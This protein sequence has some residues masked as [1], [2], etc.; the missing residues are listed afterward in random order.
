MKKEWYNEKLKCPNC[1]LTFCTLPITEGNLMRFQEQYIKTRSSK[2]FKLLYDELLPYTESLLKQTKG[3][4][5]EDSEALKYFADKIIRFLAEEYLRDPDFKIRISFAGYIKNGHK[6]EQAL[7]DKEE[8]GIIAESLNRILPDGKEI[9]ISSK[10][11]VIEEIIENESI[12]KTIEYLTK[13]VVDKGEEFTKSPFSK[14][15]RLTSFDIDIKKNKEVVNNFFKIN[16]DYSR[17]IKNQN[18]ISIPYSKIELGKTKA[19]LRTALLTLNED[20]Y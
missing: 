3:K 16:T 18:L 15:L 2:D 20:N 5:I 13:I 7:Y 1:G 11:G 19:V 14:R 10:I 17:N 9:E 8:K 4:V 6:I 12:Y